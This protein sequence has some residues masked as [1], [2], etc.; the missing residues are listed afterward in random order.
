[1]RLRDK[2]N[3]AR[4]WSP[5]PLLLSGFANAAQVAEQVVSAATHLLEALSHARPGAHSVL[6]P[7]P[8]VGR[9][10]ASPALARTAVPVKRV[11]VFVASAHA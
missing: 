11:Q 3:G 8:F 5:A 2:R 1:M 6:E 9:P 7:L 10:Q 4:P